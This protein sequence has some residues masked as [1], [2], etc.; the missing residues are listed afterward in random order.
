[1]N[2]ADVMPGVPGVLQIQPLSMC[3]KIGLDVEGFRESVW[4][5]MQA[6]E[7]ACFDLGWS[8]W[9]LS[10]HTGFVD[11]VRVVAHDLKPGMPCVLLIVE[12]SDGVL[13]RSALVC[14]RTDV[15]P[16][17]AVPEFFPVPPEGSAPG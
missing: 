2:G 4:S 9:S 5:C 7:R 3:I 8:I 12:A 13:L 15:E 14:V 16:G 6:A 17:A 11:V 1:M 10:V